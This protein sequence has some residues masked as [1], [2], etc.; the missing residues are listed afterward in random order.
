[1]CLSTGIPREC[2]NLDD[3]ENGNVDYQTQEGSTATYTCDSGY[4]LTGDS[5]RICQSDGTWSSSAP[6]S[7][8]YGYLAN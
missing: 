6:T 5:T 8:R 3:L 7:Q 1:M 4:Q 2:P